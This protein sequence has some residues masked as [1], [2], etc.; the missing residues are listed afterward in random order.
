MLGWQGRSIGYA[1]LMSMV[2]TFPD[3]AADRLRAAAVARGVSVDEIALR[4]V[5]EHLP[6]VDHTARARTA[7]EAFIGSVSGDG[8][9]FD[10]HDARRD[11][12]ARR[13]AQGTR[14]L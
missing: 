10:I 13:W 9:R 14:S 6:A 4:L 7:L 2:I 3:D 12:A 11:L 8:S 5:V 1:G